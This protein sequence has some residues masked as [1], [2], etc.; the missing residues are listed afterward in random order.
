MVVWL[1]ASFI[2]GMLAGMVGVI[3]LLVWVTVD[4]HLESIEDDCLDF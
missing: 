3:G 1:V 4:D 2:G